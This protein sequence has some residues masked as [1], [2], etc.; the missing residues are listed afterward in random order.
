M[1]IEVIEAPGAPAASNAAIPCRKA[2][3]DPASSAS[4]PPASRAPHTPESTSPLPA[5]ARYDVDA[6]LTRASPDGDA[7]SRRR[8]LEQD[9]HTQL[10]GSPPDVVEPAGLDVGAVDVHQP[11]ELSRMRGEQRRRT[12]AVEQLSAGGKPGDRV[13][14]DE[15]R[16]VRGENRLDNS[17]GLTVRAQARAHHPG[18]NPAGSGAPRHHRRD[19][20][21]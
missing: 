8:A 12:A 13:R 14:V 2:P 4:R 9:R 18:L 11:R 10:V 5:V 6:L 3:A 17:T 16:N 7:T 20:P 21:R 15:D 1:S 19:A